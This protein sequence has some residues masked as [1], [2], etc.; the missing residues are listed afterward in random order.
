MPKTVGLEYADQV[1]PVDMET[2]K[3]LA[4]IQIGQSPQALLYAVNAITNGTGMG[5]LK[6]LQ[7]P[8]AAQVVVMSPITQATKIRGELSVR[9]IGASDLVEQLFLNLRPNTAYTLALS[10]SDAA[11]YSPDY[12]INSF[13][14]DEK[15]KYTGL[16]TGL[17]KS[18]LADSL[19]FKRLV[20]IE[21][22]TSQ[23]V[24][25]NNQ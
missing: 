25:V 5:N 11:P 4:P 14:T 20:L 21:V 3:A 12:E 10:R 19:S 15:A 22:S 1:Q 8:N 16:S 2:M 7:D 9:T 24:M 23:P 17:I 18:R 13:V 6:P